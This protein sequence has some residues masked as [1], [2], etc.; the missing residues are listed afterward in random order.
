MAL[1][2]AVYNMMN[3]CKKLM[4]HYPKILFCNLLLVLVTQ[5]SA[6]EIWTLN[7]CIAYSLENNLTLKNGEVNRDMQR[8]N[9]SQARLNQLPGMSG[10]VGI[11]ESFGRSVDPGTNTYTDVNYYNNT[12]EVGA[13]VNLFSGFIQRNRI[14]FERYNLQVEN[15]RLIQQKNL[16]VYTVIEAYFNLLLKRGLYSLALE[17]LNLMQRQRYNTQRLIDV[18][19]K[20]ESDIFDFDAKLAADSFLLIQNEGILAKASLNLKRIM[21]F[22]FDNTLSIDSITPVTPYLTDTL[23]LKD[24]LESAKLQLPDLKITGDQLI[25]AK[26]YL[27]QLRGAFSPS[28]QLYAGWDTRF[29][30]VSSS[31]A[32]PFQEQFKNNAG[33]SVGLTL[34]IPIFS[35]F[36]KI[37]NVRLA[38][39]NYKK[40]EILHNEN[41]QFFENEV[42]SAYIDWQTAKNEYSSAQKQL[43][44][45]RIAFITAEK[46]LELG[47]INVI[48]F[49]IQ[50][51]ELLRSRSELLRTGLGLVF[52]E[53]YIRFLLNGN[54]D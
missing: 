43:E 21:N 48:D 25:A 18:G 26:K 3:D 37:N 52:I 17:D 40:A 23:Q 15:N 13:S 42:N 12:Y 7:R 35:R 53:K 39:L 38:K 49:Y 44:K 5:I 30:K 1:C 31:K 46:K 8:I 36:N 2:L 4:I 16:V 54:W 6:Q 9:L 51:N 32:L 47:Q 11:S 45:T 29:Y 27:A 41:V 34:S 22:P 24:L 14:A 20:A 33:E 50:K 19:R 28:L 10:S